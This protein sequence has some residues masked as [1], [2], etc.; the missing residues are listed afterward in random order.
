LLLSPPNYDLFQ[1]LIIKLVLRDEH[2]S[3]GLPRR[4][5]S[6]KQEVLGIA[7]FKSAL[8]HF[9]HTHCIDLG[10]FTRLTICY[11]NDVRHWPFLGK[12]PWRVASFSHGKVDRTHHGDDGVIFSGR[13]AVPEK[14]IG[15]SS[16]LTS[17]GFF[18]DWIVSPAFN[19]CTPWLGIVNY[20]SG[21]R[22]N[23]FR[24]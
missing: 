15:G 5:R 17:H 7:C 4:R 6:F 1:S 9:A 3:A 14:S 23:V 16:D 19:L 20:L 12:P 11:M 24:P 2:E 13:H 22:N 8:L 10:T 18:A 21:V